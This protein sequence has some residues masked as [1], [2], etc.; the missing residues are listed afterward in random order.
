MKLEVTSNISV[1]IDRIEAKRHHLPYAVDDGAKA[2]AYKIREES[3]K[4]L[5]KLYWRE[6]EGL[7]LTGRG[8][9]GRYDYN[10]DWTRIG[11]LRAAETVSEIFGEGYLV[12]T[13]GEVASSE[14]LSIAGG[15]SVEKNPED[16]APY[17]Y[18]DPTNPAF[19]W[20]KRGLMD[21][22]A[23]IK[24]TFIEAYARTMKELK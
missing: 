1:V 14:L 7:V 4:H 13:V 20:R 15:G 9:L 12:S 22:K 10:Y 18:N 11:A 19:E 3:L 5:E 2:V 21:A 8:Y 23:D 16:Y 24:Q 17:I 6:F